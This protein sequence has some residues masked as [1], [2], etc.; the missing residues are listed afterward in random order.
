M[1]L[2]LV[3]LKIRRDVPPAEV[4]RVF[5]AVG[6]LRKVIP[7]ITDYAW[8]PYA[9]PE[10][11]NRGFTHGFSMTFESTAA[12]DVYLPH[13]KHDAVKKEVLALLDGGLAGAL[14]FDFERT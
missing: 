6:A 12:R 1:I 7:G 14:A 2:H 11:L 13:P 9:S 10:G 5:E 3:L 8:G 4:A